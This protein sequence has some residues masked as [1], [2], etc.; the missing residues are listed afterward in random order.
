MAAIFANC[1]QSR[2]S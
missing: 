2:T 1:F